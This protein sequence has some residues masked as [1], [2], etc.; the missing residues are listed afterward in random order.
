M[1]NF[2][3]FN[4]DP[5]CYSLN[6]LIVSGMTCKF[7]EDCLSVLRLYYLKTQWVKTMN[8]NFNKDKNELATFLRFIQMS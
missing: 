4:K 7:I 5:G 6:V 2:I 3:I 1:I 8:L